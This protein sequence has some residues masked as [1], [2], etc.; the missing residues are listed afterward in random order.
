[1]ATR[2]HWAGCTPWRALLLLPTSRQRVPASIQTAVPASEPKIAQSE[3][4]NVFAAEAFVSSASHVDLL[5]LNSTRPHAA[6][7][8]R[9]PQDSL[10]PLGHLIFARV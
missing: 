3:S 1:M 10:P 7:A 6:E 2:P 5:V 8:Q 4:E 9:N